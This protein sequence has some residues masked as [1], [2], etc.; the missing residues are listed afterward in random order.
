MVRTLQTF[1]SV[2]LLSATTTAPGAPAVAPEPLILAVHPYL[3]P[4]EII[5]RFTP[6][7]EYLARAVGRP[8][9]VRV[10]PNTGQHIEAVGRNAVDIAYI[11]PYA[12]V[13]MVSAHGKKP[14]LARVAFKGKL[15]LSSYIVTRTDSP[16]QTLS[17]LRGKRF[18]FG[19]PDAIMSTLMP[20]YALLKAGVHLD[21]LGMYRYIGSQA[22]IALGVLNDDFDAGAVREEFFDEFG[23]RGLRIL[24]RLPEVPVHLF[25]TRSDMPVAQVKVLREALLQLQNAPDGAAILRAIGQDMTAMLP[26]TDADYDGMRKVLRAI[27]DE[28]G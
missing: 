7:A 1:L 21:A 17:D 2:L 4:A 26:V 11:G 24:A 19:D 9:A 12:Y 6:L 3:P 28:R 23:A 5:T 13:R 16:F 22:N 18:A 20:R 8:V 10:G 25:V 14:L 15:S 27:D